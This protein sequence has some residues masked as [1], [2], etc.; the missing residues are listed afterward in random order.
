MLSA[1]VAQRAPRAIPGRRRHG[2][3][4]RDPRGGGDAPGLVRR[5]SRPSPPDRPQL[6]ALDRPVLFVVGQADQFSPLPELRRLAHRIPGAEVAVIADTDHF[7]WRRERE[8]AERIGTFADTL[9]G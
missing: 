7:F 8:V 2:P 4:G 9:L 3:G 6:A 5:V 1:I